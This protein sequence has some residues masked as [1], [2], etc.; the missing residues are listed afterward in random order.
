VCG[1]ATPFAVAQTRPVKLNGGLEAEI[2]S[3][4]RTKDQLHV[5]VQLRIRNLGKN[6]AEVLFI[7][8]SAV[9]TD[10]TGGIFSTPENV[11]GIAVCSNGNG[12]P[13][14]CLGIPEKVGTTVELQN[15]TQIDPNPDPDAEITINLRLYGQGD[16]PLI[17]F[18]ANLFCRFIADP[19]KDATLSDSDRYR[20]F[21]IMSL[22]FPSMPVTDA[23]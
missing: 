8:T 10:N 17:S 13:S 6:V 11:S 1:L 14:N 22:S 15:F 23:K 12:A 20:Q 3:L 2:V 9:A 5:T 18:S 19:V 4:G 7:R 21:R 16:G